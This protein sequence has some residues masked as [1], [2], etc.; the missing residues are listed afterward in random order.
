[1]A[2][3]IPEPITVR[4]SQKSW[5]ILIGSAFSDDLEFAGKLNPFKFRYRW[6]MANQTIN[7]VF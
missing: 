4:I 6:L 7:Q 1:V 5:A 2:D 3:T